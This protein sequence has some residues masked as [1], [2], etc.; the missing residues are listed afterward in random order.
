MP[1][2]RA[3]AVGVTIIIAQAFV[4]QVAAEIIYRPLGRN[5][6]AATWA[7]N[8]DDTYAIT[9]D[10]RM[11]DV[12]DDRSFEFEVGHFYRRPLGYVPRTA[13][14]IADL[15]IQG[16]SDIE[17][18]L[19]QMRGFALSAANQAEDEIDRF[20]E[21]QSGIDE[22]LFA[23]DRIATRLSYRG[24]PLLDG[25]LGYHSVVAGGP[26]AG[27]TV[28]RVTAETEPG[29]YAVQVVTRGQRA[30]VNASFE[31]TSALW[32][33]EILTING[34]NIYLLTG[35]TQRDVIDRINEHADRT[36]VFAGF[37]NAPGFHFDANTILYTREFGSKAELDVISN[38][39]AATSTSGFPNSTTSGRGVDAVITIGAYA[40]RADG[41]TATATVDEARGMTV[42]LDVDPTNVAISSDRLD[43]VITVSDQSPTFRLLPGDVQT[44]ATLSLPNVRT[45]ALGIGQIISQFNTLADVRVTDSIKAQDALAVIDQSI[46][47]VRGYRQDV[48][49]FL[50]THH[51]PIGLAELLPLESSEFAA[52]DGLLAVVHEGDLI[53]PQAEFTNQLQTYDAGLID[54]GLDEQ[55][56]SRFFGFRFDVDG[57]L[58]YG[59]LRIGFDA[60]NRMTL[61][62]LAYENTPD[63]PI[64]VGLVPEPAF[65][66]WWL[67]W[68]AVMARCTRRFT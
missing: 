10:W 5:Q 28:N 25:R 4:D 3:V 20:N 41:L 39:A 21:N 17:H 34:V 15:A 55:Q 24:S 49:L 51:L 67:A 2:L 44:D 11:I 9:P 23:I 60:D 12:N 61:L 38:Q 36:G 32:E 13:A 7:T 27:I 57:A 14:D 48:G 33:D 6:V 22:Q 31:Q 35:M 50:R 66:W 56:A 47:E 62:D 52:E 19:G 65:A 16:L 18:H 40:Y 59:W 68:A 64:R 43:A 8:D 63:H 37:Q 54:T 30:V 1:R 42:T 46:D 53:G 45:N 26:A 29:N 58:H